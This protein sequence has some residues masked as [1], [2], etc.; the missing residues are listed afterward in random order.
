MA[1][2][3]KHGNDDWQNISSFLEWN[4]KQRGNE[5]RIQLLTEK[6]GK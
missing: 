6:P 3:I 2:Y 5:F 1:K 4:R